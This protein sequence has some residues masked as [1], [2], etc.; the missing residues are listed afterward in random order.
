MQL[1]PLNLD[2]RFRIKP[3]EEI[4]QLKMSQFTSFSTHQK[5]MT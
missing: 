3:N 1:Q 2:G 5:I 4:T